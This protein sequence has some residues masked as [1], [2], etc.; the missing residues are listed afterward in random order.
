VSREADLEKLNELVS[1]ENKLLESEYD[2][3]YGMLDTLNKNKN[4]ALSD[5]QRAWVDKAYE[6]FNPKYENL[7]SA[8]KAP[9]GR[10]VET[11]AVLK[12]LPK[13]PPGR[14]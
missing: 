6:R 10:E 2:A 11:P 7:M 4:A 8:G 13:R 3:F 12:N 14:S 9:R 1:W 5:K